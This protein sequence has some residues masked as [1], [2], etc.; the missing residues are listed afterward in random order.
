MPRNGRLLLLGQLL[1]LCASLAAAVALDRPQDWEPLSLFW[2]LSGLTLL[3]GSVPIVYRRMEAS[4]AFIGIV[5]VAV[6]LGPAPAVTLAAATMLAGSLQR[7]KSLQDTIC[8]VAAFTTFAA[9]AGGL[10][11]LAEALQI[12]HGVSLAIAVFCVFLATNVLNFVLVALD[13]R[14]TAGIPVGRAMRTVYLPCV[15]V[16][17][18][19]AALTAAL[20]Y[21]HERLGDGVVLF[22]AAVGLAFQ[23]LLHLAFEARRR[24]EALELRTR[25]LASLQ[26]GLL[27]T[28]LRTL[29]LRDKMTARHSAA[30]ARYARAVAAHIGLAEREQDLIH[31]AALLHDIGKFVFPDSI[32]LSSNRLSDA[33]FEIVKSHPSAG[34]DLL[35]SIEGYGPVAEIVVAHHERVDGRGYPSRLAG[36]AIPVGARII[37]VCDTFDVMTAR[38]SYRAPVSRAEAIA[39][40]R[41]VAGSQLDAEIVEAFV[42]LVEDHGIAF[43][44]TDDTDFER[45]LDLMARIREYARPRPRRAAA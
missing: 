34:A 23:Y 18:A 45:E 3:S 10:M 31:T 32:L 21:S 9:A 16:E 14:V 11:R 29:S 15:P 41:R 25:E 19:S 20:A 1:L 4:A 8:N 7:R 30:V 39:E 27:S 6:L 22:L 36:E 12:T 43:R 28:V 5:L 33:D 44:H 35:R 26:V 38:D 13:F 2:L 42:E 37:A 24:G 40:L 17:I